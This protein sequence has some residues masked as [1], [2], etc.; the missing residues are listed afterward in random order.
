MFVVFA[1]TGM[2]VAF[3]NYLTFIILEYIDG[4]VFKVLQQS[5]LLAVALVAR[6]WIGAK[7]SR[8]SWFALVMVVATAVL[9]SQVRSLDT[10]SD[11]LFALLGEQKAVM[12][13]S[14]Y[15]NTTELMQAAEGARAAMLRKML[16]AEF[17]T[18]DA[19]ITL[20]KL[21]D[22]ARSARPDPVL[23]ATPSSGGGSLVG[24]GLTFLYVCIDSFNAVYEQQNLQKE[25]S[26]PFYVQMIYKNVPFTLMGILCAV[27]VGPALENMGI[28]KKATVNMLQDGFFIGWG[29]A[30]LLL[31]FAAMVAKD[32]FSGIVIKNLKLVF[33]TSF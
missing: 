4:D 31:T 9:F 10:N 19:T 16:T 30:W 25:K 7:H 26:T 33:C 20:A 5:R 1:P 22:K 6:A 13:E 15:A 24:V 32:W 3:N 12:Y 18:G 27:F 29:S 28:G 8:G 11:R 23:E 17:G 14:I 2:I 21:I